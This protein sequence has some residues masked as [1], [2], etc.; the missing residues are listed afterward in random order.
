[1]AKTTSAGAAALATTARPEPDATCVAHDAVTGVAS[2]A[3]G[4]SV[5]LTSAALAPVPACSGDPVTAAPILR[6]PIGPTIRRHRLGAELK[7]LREARS[8]RLEDVAPSLGVAPSTLSRIENGKAPA[9]TSYVRILLGLYRVDDPEHR[10][11]LADLAREGQRKGWWAGYEDLLPAGAAE[12]LGLEAAAS[13]VC[14]FAVQAVPG[15]LQ[16]ADYA[17]AAW[18]ASQPGTSADQLAR[19]AE[20]TLRRQQ[21]AREGGTGL[22]VVIDEAALIRPVGSIQIMAGQMDHLAA[23]ARSVTVQVV[24]LTE[25][26]PRLSLPFTVLR[27]ADP[28]DADAAYMSNASGH[29]EIT[30]REAE[31]RALRRTFAALSKA[32]MSAEESASLFR[33]LAVRHA[34]QL[35]KA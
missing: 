26:L 22:H 31:V 2:S 7:R 30:M 15:L 25:P 5:G 14:E 34:R 8:L 24:A 21:F 18:R 9:R 27:F 23:A 6:P 19:L 13:Q 35:V 33:C 29:V 28:A 17:A 10:R 3:P 11:L 16:T 1:M 20:F 32:A 4:T 12:Y